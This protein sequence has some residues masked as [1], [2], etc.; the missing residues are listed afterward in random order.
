MEG[1]SVGPYELKSRRESRCRPFGTRFLFYGTTPHLPFGFAQ[2]RLGLMDGVAGATYW[3][4]TTPAFQ[5]RMS[6]QGLKPPCLL[7]SCGTAEAVPFPIPFVAR[8]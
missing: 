4:L 5:R 1:N 6:L 8:R 3:P 2:G 7:L